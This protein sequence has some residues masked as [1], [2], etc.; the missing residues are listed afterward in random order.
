[1]SLMLV[2]ECGSHQLSLALFDDVALLGKLFPRTEGK[3]PQHGELMMPAIDELLT[4]A[5]RDRSELTAIA[6]NTGPGSYTGLRVGVATVMGLTMNRDIE[7][8]PVSTAGFD[9]GYSATQI[10]EWVLKH[11]PN[12]VS[13]ADV[14]LSYPI[15]PNIP[16]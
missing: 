9:P 7:L 11:H 8:Y 13:L 15:D 1:M 2:L 6:F 5:G 4:R 14:K 16:G 12:P 10:G 3:R